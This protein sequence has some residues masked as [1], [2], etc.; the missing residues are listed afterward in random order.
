M[1]SVQDDMGINSAFSTLTAAPGDFIK[2]QTTSATYYDGYGFYPDINIDV[3]N[4]YLLRL[5]RRRNNGL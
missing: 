5:N 4:M 2:S 3:K 1:N